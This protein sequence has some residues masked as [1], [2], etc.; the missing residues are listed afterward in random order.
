MEKKIG[1]YEVLATLGKGAGST[2]HKIRRKSDSR[3]YALKVIEIH[4][5]DDRKY[6]D[7]AAH[8]FE[9]SQ[10]LRHPALRR[11]Y[12]FERQHKLLRVSGALEL[13]EF[14]QGKPMAQL[15]KEPLIPLLI[16]FFRT[17]DGLAYMHSQGYFHADVKPEN[18]LV[19]ADG[20]VK[21][22]D[23]GLVWKRGE[24][25]D[26]V[27]GTLEFLAP[28]QA[29]QKM[30]NEKTDI[31]NFGATMYRMLT[32]RPIP[33]QLRDPDIAG[34]KGVD[35]IVRPITAYHDHIPEELDELV[36]QCVRHDPASRPATMTEVR[37]RLRKIG[38]QVKNDQREAS[39]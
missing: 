37:D 15:P 21:I 12:A 38:K 33:S 30:V 34:L 24:Q 23:L 10:R 25:K 5:S 2:I 6:L 17:A 19:M 35:D 22:I 20:K 11:I 27:Q 13:M 16:A 3:I 39:G 4:A 1:E 28:E 32:Q 14:V 31:F 8:E 18:V 9:V 29:I 7:Q 36:R 26:R